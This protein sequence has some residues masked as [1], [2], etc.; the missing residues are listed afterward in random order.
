MSYARKNLSWPFL[1]LWSLLGITW[2]RT[3]LGSRLCTGEGNRSKCRLVSS[4]NCCSITCWISVTAAKTGLDIRKCSVTLYIVG[5]V[6][7]AN[8]ADLFGVRSLRLGTF[9]YWLKRL[10]VM[11]FDIFLH[12][13]IY[14][15][16][17]LLG[18]MV[19]SW[20]ISDRK[21]YECKQL[22]SRCW[23][24]FFS[25]LNLFLFVK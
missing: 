9:F 17:L 25:V 10:V 6:I 16:L 3:R 12:V 24:I 8:I 20:T 23:D 19:E 4:L 14:R 22:Y 11:C 21:N 7:K 15:L 18:K 2:Q 5:W 13:C 1:P